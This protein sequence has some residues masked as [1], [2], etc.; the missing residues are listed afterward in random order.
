M[1]MVSSRQTPG[2]LSDMDIL[3]EVGA[4]GKPLRLVF[5]AFD[6]TEEQLRVLHKTIKAVTHDLDSMGFNT[7]IARAGRWQTEVVE[8]IRSIR[9]TLKQDPLGADAELAKLF[10]P[11]VQALELEGEHVEQLGSAGAAP[12]A[13]K[14]GAHGDRW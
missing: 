3:A 5:H 13:L 6:P 10:R 11:Q 12:M 7:A 4:D 8:R 1:L 9:R 2:E 14:H